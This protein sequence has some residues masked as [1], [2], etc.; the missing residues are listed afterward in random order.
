VSIENDFSQPPV[1]FTKFEGD[2]TLED[3]ERYIAEMEEFFTRK[4]RYL[5]VTWLKR[6]ARSP[7]QL[8]RTATWFKERETVMREL[9]VASTIISTSP[10]FRFALSALF[11]IKPLN[12]PSSVCSTFDE[13]I[14]FGQ[15]E[16]RKRG[17]HLPPIRNP[18]A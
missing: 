10:A 4:Q 3:L 12:G 14:S 15:E 1:V 13:A 2:Q 18:W 7:E 8:R 6:Y 11:L 9:C 5:S 17:L 16:F